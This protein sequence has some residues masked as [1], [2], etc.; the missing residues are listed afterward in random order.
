MDRCRG[1]ASWPSTRNYWFESGSRADPSDGI[2]PNHAA[3]TLG[4]EFPALRTVADGACLS[5]RRRHRA[6]LARLRLLQPV[7]VG[8]LLHQRSLGS[9]GGPQS[10]HQA[11]SPA[12]IRRAFDRRRCCRGG[13]PAGGG[14][15][16][17]GTVP[18]ASLHC[19]SDALFRADDGLFILSEAG[20][21]RRRADAVRALH[22]ARAGRR[23]RH[24]GGTIVLAARVLHIPLHQSCLSEALHRTAEDEWLG[25]ER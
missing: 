19:G 11:P 23:R 21:H 8:R 4:E 1:P 6:S 18:V 20:A 13:W 3:A 24:P 25:R 9:G 7:R 16:A 17:R 15:A 22:A 2:F 5:E 14:V 10:R 12:R